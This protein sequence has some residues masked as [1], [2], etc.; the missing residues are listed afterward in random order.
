MTRCDEQLIICIAFSFSRI[1]LVGFGWGFCIGVCFG[2]A[3]GWSASNCLLYCV[4]AK[5]DARRG[6]G[7]GQVIASGW[8]RKYVLWEHVKGGAFCLWQGYTTVARLRKGW[9]SASLGR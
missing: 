8:P 6:N 3:L 5:S 9:V 4:A 1:F 7:I 2:L